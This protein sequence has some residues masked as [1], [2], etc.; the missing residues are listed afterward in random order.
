M[1]GHPEGLA[2]LDEGLFEGRDVPLHAR[3]EVLQV[4]DGVHDQLPRAMVRY[5]AAPV[6]LVELGPETLQPL[7]GVVAVLGVADADG[8]HGVVLH[9]EQDVLRLGRRVAGEFIQV[10]PGIAQLHVVGGEEAHAAE[11]DHVHQLL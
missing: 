6:R 7:L 10:R 1:R 5:Q 9:D 11:V 3:L 4:Q 2:A 8:V